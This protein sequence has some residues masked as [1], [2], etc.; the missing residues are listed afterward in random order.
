MY[1]NSYSY[2][3]SVFLNIDIVFISVNVIATSNSSLTQDYILFLPACSSLNS[4]Q[5]I[6]IFFQF[7]L[8]NSNF[9]RFFFFN[10]IYQRQRHK[11]LR[12]SILGKQREVLRNLVLRESSGGLVQTG[13]SVL[14]R[15]N[16]PPTN[17][18]RKNKETFLPRI[19][20]S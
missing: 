5:L 9:R 7:W 8:L 1:T 4:A 6:L 3:E 13:S 18:S 10:I 20:F 14:A 15:A 11:K 17:G 19:L 12:H 16:L 2:S